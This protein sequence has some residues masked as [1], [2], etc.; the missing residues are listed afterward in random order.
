VWWPAPS[1]QCHWEG[2]LKLCKGVVAES[3]L[4]LV[5]TFS[6][7]NGEGGAYDQNEA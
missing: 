7:N 1:S 5:A 3:T 6:P 2:E 4:T